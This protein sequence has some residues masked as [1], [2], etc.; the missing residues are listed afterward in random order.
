LASSKSSLKPRVKENQ[1][2]WH[3]PGT[4]A[5]GKVRRE[6][7]KFEASLGYV[8]RPCLKIPKTSRKL[9][10]ELT[11]DETKDAYI[12]AAGKQMHKYWF[13]L[14]AKRKL[15]PNCGQGNKKTQAQWSPRFQKCW[16][17]WILDRLYAK[18]VGYRLETHSTTSS[19]GCVRAGDSLATEGKVFTVWS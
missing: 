18:S 14:G 3:I 1:S 11:G 9:E 12:L 8:A 6:D 17:K 19:K 15:L 4:L 2:W 5:L 13:F 10:K 7:H 16:G